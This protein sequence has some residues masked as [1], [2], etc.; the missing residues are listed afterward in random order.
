MQAEAAWAIGDLQRANE[1]FRDAVQANARAVQPRVRWGAAVPADAS[2]RRRRGAV[3]RSAEDLPE[4]RCTRSSAWRS[5]FAERFEGEAE[6]LLEEVLQRGRR[7]DRSASAE[8]AR[9]A[10]EE[11]QV[12]AAQKA[13]D[14]AAQLAAKQK[15][16]PLEVYALRAALEMLARSRS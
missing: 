2:V 12:D 3:P 10:L 15:L 1:C 16:P 4:R 11:G 14:R 9:M 6:P 13:L 7:A 5:V 8:R